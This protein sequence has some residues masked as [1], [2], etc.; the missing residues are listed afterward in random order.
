MALQWNQEFNTE[1]FR[2]ASVFPQFIAVQLDTTGFSVVAASSASAG[3]APAIGLSKA[4]MASTGISADIQTGGWG[5]AIAGASLG[6]GAI[7]GVGNGGSGTLVPI[8]QLGTASA[9]AAQPQFAVGTALEAASAGSIF[10][11]KIA[12]RQ[13]V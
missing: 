9:N 3:V 6:I 8:K 10:T 5:K 7:V 1:T 13:V 11:V 2:A 12:P 4:T